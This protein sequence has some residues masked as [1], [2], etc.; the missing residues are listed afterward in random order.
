MNE[1]ANIDDDEKQEHNSGNAVATTV[2]ITFSAS[3]QSYSASSGMPKISATWLIVFTD[4]MALMITFFV[5]L[6]AMSVPEPEKWTQITGAMNADIATTLQA[7]P[8]NAGPNDVVN[9]RKINIDEGAD[10][11]YLENIFKEQLKTAQLDQQIS[12][13]KESHRLLL[14]MHKELF[15]EGNS[16]TVSDQG[17]ALISQLVPTLSTIDNHIKILTTQDLSD[18]QKIL[19]GFKQAEAIG[20]SFSDQGAE[21]SFR[22]E[23]LDFSNVALSENSENG[24]IAIAIATQADL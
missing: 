24:L 3:S 10:L 13:Q 6:Y 22:L 19:Q 17:R 5:L 8:L 15:F 23:V 21:R 1:S 9:I 20:R 16:L 12:L 4:L 2:G 11:D 14:M 7:K 18:A